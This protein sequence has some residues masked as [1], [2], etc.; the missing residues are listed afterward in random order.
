MDRSDFAIVKHRISQGLCL[1]GGRTF[2]SG[3]NKKG[4]EMG[5]WQVLHFWEKSLE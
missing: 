1:F 3:A 5:D 4:T 2:C